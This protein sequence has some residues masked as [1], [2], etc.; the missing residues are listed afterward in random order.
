MNLSDLLVLIFTLFIH[1]VVFCIYHEAGT[2]RDVVEVI[3][4]LGGVRCIVSDT[5]GI[6]DIV[7][8]C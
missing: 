6:R 1:F 4:D 5:A 7:S 3:M 8:L 2:T